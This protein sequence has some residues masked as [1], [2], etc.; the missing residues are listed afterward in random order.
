[1]IGWFNYVSHMFPNAAIDTEYLD[2]GVSSQLGIGVR[3]IEPGVSFLTIN[4]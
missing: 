1:M 4:L 2:F 3:M